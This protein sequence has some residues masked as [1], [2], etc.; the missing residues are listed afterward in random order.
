MR[1]IKDDLGT[2]KFSTNKALLE[3]MVSVFQ[4]AANLGEWSLTYYIERVRKE[5]LQG[6]LGFSLEKAQHHIDRALEHL[7][8]PKKKAA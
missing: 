4:S 2:P 3:H 1:E 6:D 8:L 7:E 5:V